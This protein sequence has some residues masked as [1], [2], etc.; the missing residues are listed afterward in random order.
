MDTTIAELQAATKVLQHL[1]ENARPGQMSW[2]DAVNEARK[3]ITG[4]STI[5]PY[6]KASRRVIRLIGDGCKAEYDT[7]QFKLKYL[8][9][10]QDEINGRNFT[11]AMDQLEEAIVDYFDSD[12]TNWQPNMSLAE[13]PTD[14]LVDEIARRRGVTEHR[15][16]EGERWSIEGE[17]VG[18]IRPLKFLHKSGGPTRILVVQPE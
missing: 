4:I 10:E 6:R 17:T 16:I 13:I 14:T 7:D 1:L 5:H 8:R 3:K 2:Q 15:T 18:V 11:L 12:K 9:F